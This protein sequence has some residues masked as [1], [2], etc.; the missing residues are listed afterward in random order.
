MLRDWARVS[1]RRHFLSPMAPTRDGAFIYG[2][3]DMK[4]MFMRVSLCGDILTQVDFISV[5]AGNKY[6]VVSS[7]VYDY[8]SG[9]CDSWEM[10]TAVEEAVRSLPC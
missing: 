3:H 2:L 5:A 10:E 4:A 7:D 9:G 1:R 8:A 6:N